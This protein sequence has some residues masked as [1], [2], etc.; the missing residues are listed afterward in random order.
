MEKI[1]QHW[2][3]FNFNAFCLQKWKSGLIL[4]LSCRAKL[5]CFSK[6]LLNQEINNLRKMFCL[7]GYPC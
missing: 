2:T 1:D 3:L 6:M 5:V 4:C 7:N